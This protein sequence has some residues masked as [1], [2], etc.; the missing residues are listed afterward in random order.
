MRRDTPIRV[1]IR[2]AARSRAARAVA[3]SRRSAVL[4][5][6]GEKPMRRELVISSIVFA[7]WAAACSSGGGENLE[8]AGNPAAGAQD[9]PTSTLSASLASDTLEQYAAKCDQAIGLTVP[10]F[11]CEDGTPVPMTNPHYDSNRRVTS[12]DRPN[13]LNSVCD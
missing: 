5:S 4:A 10:D 9:E 11:N 13:R 2:D 3:A 12:C 8:S 7:G 1:S 6:N